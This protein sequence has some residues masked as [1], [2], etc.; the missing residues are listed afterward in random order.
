MLSMPQN[1]V[2][3]HSMP[4]TG[5]QQVGWSI[6]LK[7][8][9]PRSRVVGVA[10]EDGAW[11]QHRPA[12]LS[13]PQ[14]RLRLALPAQQRTTAAARPVARLQKSHRGYLPCSCHV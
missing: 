12:A 1:Y 8:Y 7:L 5:W 2:L 13:S 14:G 11:A 3:G 10:A 9:W 4:E 6:A